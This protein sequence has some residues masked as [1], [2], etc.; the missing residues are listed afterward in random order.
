MLPVVKNF[1]N[2]PGAVCFSHLREAFF[3]YNYI[4][5]AYAN[6]ATFFLKDI[7]SIKHMAETFL[8]YFSEFHN[9]T[10]KIE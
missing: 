9:F 5:S 4:Y 7:M 2:R 3:D 8:L 1:T 10:K 6:D